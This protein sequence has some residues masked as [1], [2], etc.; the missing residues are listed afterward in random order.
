MVAPIVEEIAAERPEY[1]IV[2]VDVDTEG[3]LAQQYGVM[4]IPTLI[5]FNEGK[6]VADD[7]AENLSAAVTADRRLQVSIAAPAAD[8][9]AL[10]TGIKGVEKVSNL[11]SKEVGVSDFIIEVKPGA[12]IRRDLFTRLAQREWPLLSSKPLA[13][14]L[15]DIFINLTVRNGGNN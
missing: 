6:I 11:G 2:K 3:E 5:V 10:I 9:A 8:A 1:K 12:D 13:M 4:S 14:S 7:T 15:E